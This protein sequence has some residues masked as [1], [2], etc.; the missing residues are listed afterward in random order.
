MRAGLKRNSECSQVEALPKEPADFYLETHLTVCNYHLQ[1]GGAR[2][3]Q[4]ENNDL[5]REVKIALSKIK[6]E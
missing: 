4:G 2:P 1:D 6:S 5:S 3:Q